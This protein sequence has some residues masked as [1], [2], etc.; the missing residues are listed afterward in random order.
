MNICLKKVELRPDRVCYGPK[1]VRIGATNEYKL[2]DTRLIWID[3]N[4]QD[5]I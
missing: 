3:T 1:Q 4:L 2:K 5:V